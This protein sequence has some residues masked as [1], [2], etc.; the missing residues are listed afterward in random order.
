MNGAGEEDDEGAF[1][2]ILIF[3]MLK[4]DEGKN[5]CSRIY[6]ETERNKHHTELKCVALSCKSENNFE[7]D[8]GREFRV[9][10]RLR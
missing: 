7:L 8:I 2:I 5:A 3:I 6:I 10:G 9:P 4:K 1:K